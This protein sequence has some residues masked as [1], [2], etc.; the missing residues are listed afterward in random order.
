MRELLRKSSSIFT[1]LSAPC[2][3]EIFGMIS[4][5]I[6]IRLI[7]LCPGSKENDVRIKVFLNFRQ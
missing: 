7:P 2:L 1:G 3:M 5:S 6:G 4:G